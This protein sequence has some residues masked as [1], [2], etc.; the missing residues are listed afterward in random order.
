[1][2]SG[3]VFRRLK[4]A[5]YAIILL[6]CLVFTLICAVAYL[7]VKAK[8]VE[9]KF[10]KR[11]SD[12]DAVT[13]RDFDNPD[14]FDDLT[15][16]EYS[17]ILEFLFS[18][19]RNLNLSRFNVAT[20]AN[21]YVY[22]IELY[23][24]PKDEVL[25]FFS[26]VGE[27]HRRDAK[28]TVY[29]GGEAV[30]QVRVYRVYPTLEP[31]NIKL[32]QCA[33]CNRYPIPYFFKPLDGVDKKHLAKF[34]EPVLDKVHYL[35]Y[36]DDETFIR[37]C[38]NVLK[39]L[40]VEFYDS[41]Y[42]SEN[43]KCV[44]AR[45]FKNSKILP[46]TLFGL[47]FLV[48]QSSTM[49]A[50]WFIKQVVFQGIRY[51]SMD[52]LI[53][54]TNI[55]RQMGIHPLPAK[56]TSKADKINTVAIP[57]P[58][59]YEPMGKRF[60]ITGQIVEYQRWRFHWHMSASNGLKLYNLLY[61]GERII[62]ELA[63]HRLKSF[64]DTFSVRKPL[65]VACNSLVEEVDCPDTAVF[66]S[67]QVFADSGEVKEYP[68][69]ICIFE[70]NAGV[71]LRRKY[72]RNDDKEPGFYS[73][74]V[75]YYLVVRTIAS[76]GDF[77]YIFDYVFRN[78]GQFSVEVRTSFANNPE[79]NIYTKDNILHPNT[80]IV[81]LFQFKVDLDIGESANSFSSVSSANT[82]MSFDA[83]GIDKNTVF[84]A[85][86]VPNHGREGNYY[87][88]NDTRR[89]F[90]IYSKKDEKT[91]KTYK[92]INHSYDKTLRDLV[93]SVYS[94]TWV[95]YPVI[96]SKYSSRESLQDTLVF[97]ENGEAQNQNSDPPQNGDDLVTWVTIGSQ[98]LPGNDDIPFSMTHQSM[99]SFTIS[100]H[101]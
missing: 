52:D 57:G 62:Y 99:C 83:E 5:K 84:K 88:F 20:T 42:I 91:Y 21:N 41:N 26:G 56:D 80:V 10:P 58:T 68:N 18:Q 33:A 32:L 43:I 89:Q 25:S 27:S 82:H 63:L 53:L 86:I 39:C 29:F 51:V 95:K 92:V 44:W 54:N 85:D 2:S 7:A 97:R 13:K 34:I 4:V 77:D 16:A 71:P 75:D 69:N 96:V 74:A 70:N 12:K 94:Q 11:F 76:L 73:G 81:N 50:D 55:T 6:L 48:D 93:N 36:S 90:V 78:S 72:Y 38:P 46:R 1:M 37:Y 79:F 66:M 40:I 101:N 64:P 17:S 15:V 87:V 35:F 67:S 45:V 49:P 31:T 100:P 9:C 23:V 24:A 28:V 47:D 8:P 98:Y 22:M 19:Q 14:V 61:D 30:P 65:G 60:H 59:L 3:R